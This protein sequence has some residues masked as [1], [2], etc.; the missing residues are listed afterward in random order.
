MAYAAPEVFRGQR[1]RWTDQYALA[2][3][4]C[5]VRGG[6]LPFANAPRP[7]LVNCVVG[8]LVRH[9]IASC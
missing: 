7:F 5:E 3:S 8:G 2:V 9:R 6:R 4:Y 1:S